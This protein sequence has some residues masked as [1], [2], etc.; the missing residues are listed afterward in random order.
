VVGTYIAPG[1]LT[2]RAFN[3]V[4]MSLVRI[5]VNV[6]G[7]RVL[8][9]KGRK[10]GKEHAVPVHVLQFGAARYLVA[11][12]GTTQWVRNIRAAGTGQLR[13][14]RKVEEFRA[15]EVADDD[16]PEILREYIRLWGIETGAFF[17]GVNAKSSTEDLRRTAPEHPVFSVLPV[18]G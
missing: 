4:Y 12:R 9:V 11:P 17:E 8:V 6:R 18:T 3:P 10:S 5:G 2:R 7:S 15:L 13:L 1:W 16:K 14:G